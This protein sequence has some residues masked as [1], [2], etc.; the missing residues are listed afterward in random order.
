MRLILGF[1]TLATLF[2]AGP[3]GASAPGTGTPQSDARPTASIDASVRRMEYR[4]A[5]LAEGAF[6]APNRSQDL[7]S[8]VSANGLEVFPRAADVSGAGAP[9]RLRL[10]TKSFGR[11]DATVDL[12][13]ATLSASDARIELDH[14]ALQEWFANDEHGIEQGWT[15]AAR[16]GG[17]A[18]LW[19]G[20]EFGG[21][22][23]LRIDAGARS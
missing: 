4:W 9:W 19:I 13:P 21:D 14:G 11:S 23:A 3:A 10:G 2:I 16:P 8:E 7:R 12:T 18:R 22:L 5:A 15:I 6:T 20:L 17:D 1:W